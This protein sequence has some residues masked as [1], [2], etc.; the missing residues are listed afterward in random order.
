MNTVSNKL[1]SIIRKNRD[2]YVDEWTIFDGKLLYSD[3][4][5]FRIKPFATFTTNS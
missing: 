1:P 2:L 5:K 3:K 4:D